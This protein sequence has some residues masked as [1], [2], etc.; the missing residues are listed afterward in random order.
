MRNSHFTMTTKVRVYEACPTKCTNV[1]CLYIA[2]RRLK[3]S[4]F[5]TRC[6][7]STFAA[8]QKNKMTNEEIFTII[9]LERLLTKLK[10]MH[11][12]YI[13]HIWDSKTPYSIYSIP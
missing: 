2:T 7:K 11:H 6:L 12:R 5:N 9:K 1:W 8:S 13:R 3:L 4:V 10:F